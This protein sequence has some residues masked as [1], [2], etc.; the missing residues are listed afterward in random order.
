MKKY[1]V[2]MGDGFLVELGEAEIRKDLEEGT[3]DAAERAAVP[4]LSE[5]ELNHL[6]DIYSSPAKFVSVD[7]GNEVVLTYDAGTLKIRRVGID[8]GR[9]HALQIY[10]KLLG[11]DTMELAHVD[12]S[13][14]SIKPIVGNEQPILEQA[15]LLSTVPLFYGAMPNL[16]IYSQPDGPVPNPS[17]LMPK[18]R[19]SEA[20]EAQEE[21]V[22]L[23]VKD[24]VYVAS[25]MYESGSDGINFD[26]TGAAGDPDV[27]ATLRATKILKEKYPEICIELGMAGEFILGMHGEME[28]EGVRLAGLYPHEQ[29]KLAQKA[30]VTIFGPVVNTNT[31]KSCPWNL[32]RAVTF[33]KPCVEN[34]NIPVHVNMGMGVGAVPV[35][36]HPP[37][38]A[39]SRASKA[40][41]EICRLDGL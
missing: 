28:Y 15:L 23:A 9:I 34:A 13:Y 30:G 33:I 6:F 10:E 5:D 31:T 1:L 17:E 16:G 19:I 8:V 25:A 41:V 24:M 12:Y 11:A 18:G 21:A 7:I 20:R 27:L 4:P 37:T 29:V 2:R 38:D 3:K 40:M 35:M 14:K 22:E 39:V 36:D 32:A 26:T